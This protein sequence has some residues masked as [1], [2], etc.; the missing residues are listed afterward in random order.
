MHF[1]IDRLRGA[2]AVVLP[3]RQIASQEHLVVRSVERERSQGFAHPPFADHAARQVGRLLDVVGSS[4][5]DLPEDDL[6]GEPAA[7][8]DRDHRLDVVP[9]MGAPI[10]LRQQHRDP[11]RHPARNDADLV[12]RVGL[13]EQRRHE[14]VS[15]LVIRRRAFLVRGH[16]DRAALRAHEDLVLRLLEV[17]HAHLFLGVPRRVQSRLVHE[18]GEV[19]PRKAGGAPRDD[20]EVH[21]RFEGNA[22]AVDLED[23]LP[24]LDVG[25]GHHDPAIEPSGAQERRIQH[26]RPVRRGDQD[27][28]VVGLEAVHFDEQLVQGLFPL[29]VS[30]AETRS[31][32]AAHGVDLV[33]EDDARRVL[34]ALFEQVAH[35]AGPDAHEH[36]DE[37]RAADGEEGN[38]GFPGDG[39]G[40]QGLA[41]SGR[42]HEQHSLGNPPSEALELL[43]F[44]EEID[45]FLKLFLWL[46][47]AGHVLEGDLLLLVRRQLRPAAPE[48][49]GAIARRL[50]LPNEEEEESHDEE[51]RQPAQQGHDPGSAAGVV[52]LHVDSP[53]QQGGHQALHLRREGLEGLALHVGSGDLASGAGAADADIGDLVLFHALHELGER[54]LVLLFGDTARNVPEQDQ[55]KR[56]RQPEHEVLHRRTHLN[57]TVRGGKAA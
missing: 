24:A 53:V 6:L 18:V 46:V 2:L 22:G 47:D 41:R 1:R 23:S 16:D 35:P 3:G 14:R 26:V 5:R 9:V 4:G 13:V 40:Q 31:P 11:H 50:H 39:A 25:K 55:H 30:A 49:H 54:E 32:L 43:R 38:V 34:L 45:D 44:L 15:G 27:D 10:V 51:D 19:R 56:G 33:D 29:I 52:G 28:A 17:L 42:P 8:L 20:A 36:F 7:H 37:V 48:G 12:Q 21:V 57:A